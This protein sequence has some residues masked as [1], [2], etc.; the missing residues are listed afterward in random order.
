[1]ARVDELQSR[2][3]SAI[4]LRDRDELVDKLLAVDVPV[5]PVLD[6]AGMLALPHLQERAVATADSWADPAVGYPV[7]FERHPAARTSPPPELDEH[8][9]AGFLLRP[10]HQSANSG[11][12]RVR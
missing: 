11:E 2:V 5:A 1:M 8:R 9:G 12:K 3:A 6:R 10:D 7:A 4:A